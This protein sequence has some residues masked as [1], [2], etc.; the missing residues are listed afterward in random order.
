AEAAELL[1]RPH[2][3]SGVVVRGDARG[4]TLGYPTANLPLPAGLAIPADGIYAVRVGGAIEADG[5]A[6]LGVRPTFGTSGMRLRAVDVFHFSGEL[7][8]TTLDVDFVARRRGEERFDA[9]EAV[10]DQMDRDAR[11]ARQVLGDGVSLPPGRAV[12]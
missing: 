4:R 2:R 3:V 12:T 1:G 7:Y 8:G 5:V 6:S 10:V 9:V 11:A